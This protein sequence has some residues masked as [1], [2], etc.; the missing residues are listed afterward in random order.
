MLYTKIQPQSFL[1]S[2][3]KNKCS[4]QYMGIAAYLVDRDRLYKFS[5][6]LNTSFHVNFE[7]NWPNG[8]REED[9]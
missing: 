2:G 1:G 8:F 9:C 4:L 7:E 5:I 3:E 6:P